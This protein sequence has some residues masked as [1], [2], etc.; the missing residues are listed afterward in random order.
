MG[1]LDIWKDYDLYLVDSQKVT[2]LSI[3]FLV[4]KSLFKVP[5]RE[6]VRATGTKPPTPMSGLVF[7]AFI[8]LPVLNSV[9]ALSCSVFELDPV[10]PSAVFPMN[11]E[12]HL[13]PATSTSRVLDG[14]GLAGGEG[15]EVVGSLLR[16]RFFSSFLPVVP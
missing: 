1:K 6:T 10:L 2:L 16:L 9:D 11:D 7:R 5:L 8:S 14:D 4:V 12:S 15:W 13:V 3:N